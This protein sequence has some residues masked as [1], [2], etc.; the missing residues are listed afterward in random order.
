M[1]LSKKVLQ[2]KIEAL[3][4]TIEVLQDKELMKVFRESVKAL[5]NGETVA[6]EDAKRELGLQ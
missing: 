4:E 6:W 5:E 1:T 3:Q 2:E